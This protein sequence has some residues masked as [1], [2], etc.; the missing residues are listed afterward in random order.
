MSGMES[1][2]NNQNFEQGKKGTRRSWSKFEEDAFFTVVD[3]FVAAGQSRETSSFKYGTMDASPMSLNKEGSQ[4]MNSQNKRKRA[5]S[6]SDEEKILI[7]LEKLFEASGKKMQMQ[8]DEWAW[9]AEKEKQVKLPLCL[10][11]RIRPQ[12][13]FE[14]VAEP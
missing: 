2:G 6:S 5:A 11:S 3:E 12:E 10:S 13:R 14:K 7:V 4:S 8:P 1:E 9:A